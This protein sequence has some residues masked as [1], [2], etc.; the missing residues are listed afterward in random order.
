MKHRQKKSGITLLALLLLYFFTAPALLAGSLYTGVISGD[1]Q[2][3]CDASAQDKTQ[4]NDSSGCCD[5]GNCVCMS[6]AGLKAGDVL[7][8]SALA[9][10]F[11]VMI[12]PPVAARSL[13]PFL[14]PP[15]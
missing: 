5:A 12:I 3:H 14:H 2:Q 11:V 10:N 4:Q 7:T 9:Q 6:V 15:A 1:G 8:W 13:P